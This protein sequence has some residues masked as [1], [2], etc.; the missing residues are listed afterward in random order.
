VWL[1]RGD[2]PTGVSSAFDGGP[3]YDRIRELRL[4]AQD[5]FMAHRYAECLEKLDARKALGAGEDNDLKHERSEALAALAR[6][7]GAR[8]GGAE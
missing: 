3:N 8:E 5:A 2:G 4:Q 1:G 7:A 6:E